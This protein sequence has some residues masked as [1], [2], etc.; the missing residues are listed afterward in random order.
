MA[1]TPQ[2]AERLMVEKFRQKFRTIRDA[3]QSLDV[4]G[5]GRIA[6]VELQSALAQSFDIALSDEI[7]AAIVARYNAAAPSDEPSFDF[8]SF[9]AMYDGAFTRYVASSI[10]AKAAAGAS[11]LQ[12]A[13]DFTTGEHRLRAVDPTEEQA[14]LEIVRRIGA[15]LRQH[16][17]SSER[18]RHFTELFLRMD[19]DRTGTLTGDEIALGMSQ[20]GLALRPSELVQLLDTLDAGRTGSISIA[21]FMLLVQRGAGTDTAP[22]V[23]TP[24]TVEAMPASAFVA[25][26]R[27]VPADLNYKKRIAEGSAAHVAVSKIVTTLDDRKIKLRAA[28][29]KLDVDGDSSISAEDLPKGVSSW[30]DLCREDLLGPTHT[31]LLL[32]CGDHTVTTA[33][34][35]VATLQ[36]AQ[37]GIYISPARARKMVAHFDRTGDH[38]LHYHEFVRLLSA[39]RAEAH[40]ERAH[41][42]AAAAVGAGAGAA[43]SPADPAPS[44]E[45]AAAAAEAGP[46]GGEGLTAAGSEEGGMGESEA[47]SVAD[48]LAAISF[49]VYSTLRGARKAFGV[50]APDLSAPLPLPPPAR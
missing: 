17:Q 38:R 49:S 21:D 10:G 32:A 12:T 4:R 27:M 16:A 24:A 23:P 50:T 45:P 47:E 5:D 8:A 39:T 43:A 31:L 2:D 30:L 22:A 40:E 19:V 44:P 28:F 48:I 7:C 34:A 15:K 26:P 35:A 41:E 37:I 18:S 11:G 36:L 1:L 20:L 13:F 46:G 29:K 25:A 42:A 6:T 3:F 9:A 14:A 33:S